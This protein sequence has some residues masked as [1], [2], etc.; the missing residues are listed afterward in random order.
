[1][2]A[3]DYSYFVGGTSIAVAPGAN[4]QVLPPAGLRAWTV[5]LSSGGSSGVAFVSGLSATPVTSGFMIT[6]APVTVNGPATFFL[7]AAGST[8]VV[9]LAMHFSSGFSLI[10]KF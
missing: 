4:V 2:S 8:A 3:N 1:M 10:G 7:A 5:A 6:S 9:G